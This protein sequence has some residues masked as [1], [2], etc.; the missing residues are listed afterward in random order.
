MLGC[1][2]CD[3]NGCIACDAILG[4]SLNGT[5]CV[6]DFGYYVSP[7]AVCTQ[8]RIEGCLDCDTE[9]SCV[10]CDTSTYFLDVD[11]GK[12][13]EICGDGVLFSLE[14][15]DNNTIDGDGCSSVCTIEKDFTCSGGSS[16][17]P[18]ACSYSGPILFE[19]ISYIK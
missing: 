2:D 4:F 7:M 9:T 13:I 19:L 18:S 12:C 17:T 6:C 1:T 11:T 14:C 16:L 8:C 10:I 15:D 5:D 3:M